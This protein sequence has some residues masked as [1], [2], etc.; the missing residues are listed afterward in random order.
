MRQPALM[1]RAAYP[2]HAYRPI[3][4]YIVCH[5]PGVARR[6]S[7]ERDERIAIHARDSSAGA[8]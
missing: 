5:I 4:G 3:G 2:N 1:A 7:Q 8:S 6:L